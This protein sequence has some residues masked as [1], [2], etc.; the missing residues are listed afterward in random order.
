MLWSAEQEANTVGSEGLHCKSSILEV[1]DKKGVE[2]V[3]NPEVVDVVKYIF[4]WMS[5]VNSRND[6]GF[7][8]PE[9]AQSMANPSACPC[10]PMLKTG[11]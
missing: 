6:E 8:S 1:W 5:P 9:D 3:L 7:V 2:R 11:V 4:E 10:E